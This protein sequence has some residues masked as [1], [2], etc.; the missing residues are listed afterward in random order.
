M[1]YLKM[2]VKRKKNY[3][4]RKIYY[5]R[6]IVKNEFKLI[7]MYKIILIKFINFGSNIYEIKILNNNI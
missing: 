3:V 5:L 7:L 6:K 4:L 2:F 1:E